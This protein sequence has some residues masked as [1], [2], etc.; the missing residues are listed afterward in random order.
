MGKYGKSI[1]ELRPQRY[2]SS[3]SNRPAIRD[4]KRRMPDSSPKVVEISDSIIE[5]EF[6]FPE[7]EVE[8]PDSR[9]PIRNPEIMN[10]AKTFEDARKHTAFTSPLRDLSN[11]SADPAYKYSDKELKHANRT[12]RTKDELLS[13]MILQI[14]QELY[15]D[16][17]EKE[18]M[19]QQ[20]IETEIRPIENPLPI[21][22]WKRKV[23]A[24]YD[25]RKDVFIPCEPKET[26]ENCTVLYYQ[27]EELISK[28]RNGF[29]NNTIDACEGNII[30]LV[31]GYQNYLTKAKNAE[32]K[33]YTD[34]VKENLNKETGDNSQRSRKR[35]TGIE[36]DLTAKEIEHL[37]N[38]LQFELNLNIIPV[39]NNNDGIDWLLS[40]TYTI[41]FALYDKFERNSSLAN[42]GV[43]KSGKDYKSTFIQSMNHFKLMTPLKS[44][45]LFGYYQSLQSIFDRFNKGKDLGKDDSGK[46]IVP[47]STEKAMKNFF[48]SDDPNEIIND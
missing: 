3:P 2:D 17:F 15:N 6:N 37:L 48:T 9:S 36:I 43:V 20:F 28:I 24:N 4:H 30:I 26:T 12:H 19:K 25:E 27:A 11:N 32:N 10:R 1:P 31:E 46:T 40:F 22:N 33:R 41:A 44:E 38:K 47:P 23:K 7:D 8:R 42:L 34:A 5:S 39:K 45:R 13:E 14:S 21:I 16:Q 18:Y 29:I 35:N